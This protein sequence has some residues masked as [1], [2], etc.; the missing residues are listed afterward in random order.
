MF[1]DATDT[2]VYT[3]TLNLVIGEAKFRQHDSWD[4]NWGGPTFPSGVG[5]QG[6]PNIPVSLGGEYLVTFNKSTGEYNFQLIS[7]STVGVIGDATSGGWVTPTPLSQDDQNPKQWTAVLELGDGGLQFSGDNGVAVWG[8]SDFPS[9]IATLGGDTIPVTGGTYRVNFNTQTGAYSFEGITIY[10]TI[11]IIGDATPGAWDFDTDMNRVDTDDSSQWELRVVLTDGYLKFRA[12]NDWAVNWGSGD[13]PTGVGELG[14]A[15][16]PVTAGEYLILFNSFT[17]AY[18]FTEIVVP[19]RVGLVGAGTP[20]MSWDIDFFLTQDPLDENVWTYASIDLNGEVKFRA[21]SMWDVNWGATDFPEGIGVQLGP[22]IPVPAGTY[23]ITFNSNTGHYVFGPPLTSTKDVL[24][25]DNI[26]VFPN[27]AS[28]SLNID[29]S[30]TNMR[31]EVNLNVFDMHG[32]LVMSEVQHVNPQ[33]R[34]N[35]ASLQDGYYTLHISNE[36]Y[37]IGKKFVVLK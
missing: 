11:G 5:T 9:G 14:G 13:F 1:Q 3:L 10:N 22:N 30:A 28:A 32:K 16:I 35:I 7:F 6:G 33:M 20:L 17:G 36:H 29:L 23:G 37:I 21:D 18:T 25:P 19:D 2:N 15:D 26:H 34:L 4:V 31:G 27:P 24:N 8:G 12:D